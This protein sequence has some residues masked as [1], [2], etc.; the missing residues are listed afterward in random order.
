M[1]TLLL[2]TDFSRPANN[3]AEYAA[4]LARFLNARLVLVHAFSLPLGGY[5]MTA[6]LETMREMQA[7]ALEKLKLIRDQL[8]A[9]SYD[10]G[11]ETYA[12]LGATGTVIADAAT[13]LGADLLIMGMTGEAGVVKK[14][15]I[16]S[17]AL[18][19]A[20]HL[21]CP[22]LII[23]EDVQYKPI[24]TISLAA[25]MQGMDE[26]TLLYAAR[27]IASTFNAELEIVTV[28][29]QD[30]EKVWTTPENYSFVERR[31]KGFR[32]KQVHLREDNVAQALEYYFKFHE[33]DL[34]IVNPKKHTV[35]QKLFTE[36]ITRHLV[37][38]SRVPLLIIH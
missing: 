29:K 35:F 13:K 2:A 15:L 4:H 6:P 24:R 23:P 37:F 18:H 1:E 11:I 33:T 19:A 28:E 7:K 16:G 25:E 14:H 36:S 9:H 31:L 34:V 20:R 5:D 38:H 32:H 17:N 30:K 3:A 27:G 26:K 10:F 22:V 21:S 12:E 8:I